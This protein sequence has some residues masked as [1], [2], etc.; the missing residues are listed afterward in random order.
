MA[1]T[2]DRQLSNTMHASC[3]GKLER[4]S[5]EKTRRCVKEEV[6]SSL[7]GM[8]APPFLCYKHILVQSYK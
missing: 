8:L 5:V 6:S 4:S 3:K 2:F 7:L 1:M